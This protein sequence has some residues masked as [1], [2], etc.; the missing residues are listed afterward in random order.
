MTPMRAT[1]ETP[2]GWRSLGACLI[3]RFIDFLRGRNC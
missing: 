2:P 1:I 3:A